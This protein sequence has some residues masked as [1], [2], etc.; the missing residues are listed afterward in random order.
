[1]RRSPPSCG[2]N[3]S[4][5]MSDQTKTELSSTRRVLFARI[6]HAGRSRGSRRHGHH[7]PAM[8]AK[9][10]L[11]HRRSRMREVTRLRNSLSPF[12]SRL[13]LN[14]QTTRETA[15]TSEPRWPPRL[16]PT[17]SPAPTSSHVEQELVINQRKLGRARMLETQSVRE[18]AS[19]RG[20]L[21]HSVDA[22]AW[23]GRRT[24]SRCSSARS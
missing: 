14:D 17:R 8:L 1:V 11:L 10:D 6:S 3:T 4:L 18:D 23:A 22:H 12:V 16:V 13:E 5:I 15:R 7:H 2:T 24:S 20:L 9:T 21:T 19:R